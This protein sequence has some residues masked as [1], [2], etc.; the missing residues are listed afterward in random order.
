MSLRVAEMFYSVQGEGLLAGVPSVFIR[1]SGCN[2][3]CGWCDTPYAS[4]QPEGSFI[5]VENIVQT[6]Q[7]WAARHVVIT[8][9]EPMLF[10]ET[11]ALCAAL[12]EKKWHITLETAGTLPPN[13][14]A[15]HLGSVS[16]KLSGSRP[17][18]AVVGEAWVKRHEATRHRPEC[19]GAWLAGY[20]CQLKFVVASE[21]DV[22]EVEEYLKG[23]PATVPP[24][25][26]LLMPEGVSPAVLHERA[27][28]VVGW[29]MERGWRYCPRL[30]VEL[31]GNRRGT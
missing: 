26:V 11:H 16:P 5:E 28:R 14:I 20:S 8:G 4:W 29:C 24:E 19:V 2:L 12:A 31:F 23:L 10:A 3:R 7:Q 22:W 15:C 17:D 6:A 1:L 25:R 30:H 27:N 13:G 18:E 21:Q 9:G